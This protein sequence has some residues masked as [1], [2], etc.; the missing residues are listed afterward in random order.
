MYY[1]KHRLIIPFLLPALILYGV[2]VIYPYIRAF[3]I[4]LTSWSGVSANMPFVGLDNYV[5]LLTDGRFLDALLRN[6]QLLIVLPLGT[7][8]VALTFAALFTQGGTGIM[9]SGFYRVVYFFPQ[10]ISAVIVGILFQYV[11]NPRYGL[12]NTS[13]EKMGLDS[14]TRTWLGDPST[15]LWAIAFVAIWSAVGFYMVIFIASM[16]SIPTSF[17]EAAVLDGATR[18]RQFRDITLPLMWETIRT[19]LIYIGIQALDMFVLV[20]V[21]TGGGSTSASRNAE[22]VAVYMYIE[23]F[24]KSRWGAAAAVGVVLLILTM[25]VSVVIM[26]ATRRE[27]YEY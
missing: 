27:T 16:Q 7:I 9:G 6:G 19:A 17:Y 11:Y 26:R 23:A 25:L 13:L 4:S 14:L 1:Q 10:V 12:L 15:I 22:V 21:M 2:F 24:G 3:Y 20:Q 18:W 8:L 5:D